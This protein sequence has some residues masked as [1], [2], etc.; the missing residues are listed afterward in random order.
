MMVHGIADD[1]FKG[2]SSVDEL[3]AQRPPDRRESWTLKW[4]DT[5][6]DLLFFFG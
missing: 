2:I 6:K 4:T 1:A 5:A 3:L